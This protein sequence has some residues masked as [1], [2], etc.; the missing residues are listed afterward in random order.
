MSLS[1]VSKFSI[2]LGWTL[3]TKTLQ[4]VLVASGLSDVAKKIANQL[5]NVGGK[6]VAILTNDN[7][8]D[9]AEFNALLKEQEKETA[10]LGLEIAEKLVKNNVKDELTLLLVLSSLQEVKK[11]IEIGDFSQIANH[12]IIGNLL[13][14]NPEVTLPK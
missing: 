5:F 7:S 11:A 3:I 4:N 14:D 2:N 8:D 13:Q 9:K 6:S 12:A 10:L 1:K